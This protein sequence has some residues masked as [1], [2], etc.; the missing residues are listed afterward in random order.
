MVAIARPFA[1]LLLSVS[2]PPPPSLHTHTHTHTHT[3]NHARAHTRTPTHA[4]THSRKHTRTRTHTHVHT[5][6]HAHAHARTHAR[7]Q[8]HTRTRTH[9]RTHAH[10]HTHTYT[11]THTFFKEK[12]A[13]DQNS[14]S[15]FDLS[16]CQSRVLSV[17]QSRVTCQ[18]GLRDIALTWA[19][20][21]GQEPI[22]QTSVSGAG[23]T[24]TGFQWH[25]YC[26]WNPTDKASVPRHLTS[27]V[28]TSEKSTIA[29]TDQREGERG[30]GGD[31]KKK[32]KKSVYLSCAP[33][34]PERSRI[35]LNTVFYTH[36]EHLPKEFT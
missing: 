1:F 4:H 3:R 32:K 5:H 10:T 35:N 19:G 23:T 2:P 7:T 31:K 18:F 29:Q 8:A 26:L 24:F 15:D 30:S 14:E 28:A 22:S 36:V 27:F 25:S 11:H 33:Q 34:R 17:C 16:V 13:C 12:A 6:T 9:A 20:F 21:R